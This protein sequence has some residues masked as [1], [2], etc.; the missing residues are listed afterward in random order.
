MRKPFKL[1][2]KSIF[3]GVVVFLV[4]FSFYSPKDGI[5]W[6][7]RAHTN[8]TKY[9]LEIMT[10][11]PNDLFKKYS[12]EINYGVWDPD[13]NRVIKHDN[14]LQCASMINSLAKKIR[15]DD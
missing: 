4:V 14:L 6:G 5:A 11:F 7:T 3:W 1:G 10:K 15:K 12:I 13:V 9:A 2:L 8:M